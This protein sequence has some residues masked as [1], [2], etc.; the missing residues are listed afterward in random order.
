MK[1]QINWRE[2]F[3]IKG[4]QK[5]ITGAVDGLSD[6]FKAMIEST[7][8]D[9]QRLYMLN[10]EKQMDF[11]EEELQSL[12]DIYEVAKDSLSELEVQLMNT[13]LSNRRKDLKKYEVAYTKAQKKMSDSQK[14][15]FDDAEK[16]FSNITGKFD[17]IS[18]ALN[19]INLG[20]IANNIESSLGSATESLWAIRSS[21]NLTDSDMSEMK[22]YLSDQQKLLAQYG[23][24]VSK[25]EYY[26]SVETVIKEF[27][28]RDKEMAASLGAEMAK[29]RDSL[30]ISPSS[31]K[32][33]VEAVQ[34]YGYSDDF[35]ESMGDS[36]KSLESTYRT[37]ADSMLVGYERMQGQIERIA[38]G[39]EVVAQQ[40]SESLF[41]AIALTENQ[42]ISSD[43]MMS[44]FEEVLAG[45]YSSFGGS[46]VSGRKAAELIQSGRYDEAAAEILTGLGE[47]FARENNPIISAA[48][49]DAWDISQSDYDAIRSSIKE[50]A[51]AF[52]DTQGQVIST[53]SKATGE[54]DRNLKETKHV[55]LF[56]KASNWLANTGIGDFV[57]NAQESLG[58]NWGELAQLYGTVKMAKSLGGGAGGGGLLSSIKGWF[59]GGSAAAPAV[60]ESVGGGAGI[61]SKVGGLASQAAPWL[62]GI[63]GGAG[64][65]SGI[66]DLISSNEGTQKERDI[67]SKSGNIKLSGVALGAGI[68][69]LIPGVGTLIGAGV[70]GLAT[71]IFGD[72]AARAIS[73]WMDGTARMESTLNALNEASE[74]VRDTWEQKALTE[75]LLDR[76]SELEKG[77]KKAAKGTSEYNKKQKELNSVIG[78]LSSIYPEYVGLNSDNL[79]VVND[80]IESI[81]KLTEAEQKLSQVRAEEATK[82]AVEALPDYIETQK[83]AIESVNKSGDSVKALEN[84][85]SLLTGIDALIESGKAGFDDRGQVESLEE[86]S[87]SEKDALDAFNTNISD[88]A[89]EIGLAGTGERLY[90]GWES[91][92]LSSKKEKIL[93]D[94]IDAQKSKLEAD[95]KLEKTA[96]ELMVGL[97]SRINGSFE[98]IAARY[99]EMSSSEQSD[100][101]AAVVQ[102]EKAAKEFKG[103]AQYSLFPSVEKLE[104]ITQAD[105]N[106]DSKKI[107]TMEEVAARSEELSSLFRDLGFSNLADRITTDGSHAGGLD[108]VPFDGYR[109]E[110]HEG[111]KVLTKQEASEYSS[112]SDTSYRDIS[113]QLSKG[114]E[115]KSFK[116]SLTNIFSETW[117][118]AYENSLD[119]MEEVDAALI[120]RN[121]KLQEKETR[122]NSW[123]SSLFSKGSY[124]TGLDS[125]PYD[126]YQATLHS[127]ERI[128]TSDESAAYNALT[129]NNAGGTTAQGL[130]NS[131]IDI[132]AKYETGGRQNY[133]GL[134]NDD[135]GASS[136]GILQWRADRAQN[137]MQMIRDANPTEFNKTIN[138]YGASTLANM[139]NSAKGSQWG[140][141]KI[142]KNSGDDK[143][144]RELLGSGTG[145]QMQEQKANTDVTGYLNL[146]KSMGLS[147]SKALA[148]FADMVNQTGS[149]SP[150]MKATTNTAVSQGGSLDAI[151]KAALNNLSSTKTRRTGV[152]NDLKGMTLPGYADGN[153]RVSEDQIAAIHKDELI[154]PA[155]NNPYKDGL[156]LPMEG[157]SEIVKVLKE[158]FQAILRK[159]E[160]MK[161]N[162]SSESSAIMPLPSQSD[163]YTML[164]RAGGYSR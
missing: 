67:K 111:E 32:P 160:D 13:F 47:S 110:L 126:G 102:L 136:F 43:K 42:N 86:L 156:T 74:E 62:G 12:G 77:L 125:V 53:L 163:T 161:S 92:D 35:V 132:I 118:A 59:G 48:Y 121:T 124:A 154:V 20:S 80:S 144:A 56:E 34:R 123:L 153:D 5:E 151:Y 18:D 64:I 44:V 49:R 133:N 105:L 30:E 128:L 70:G 150:K 24:T 6:N 39:N 4:M 134:T 57:A 101:K 66:S 36:L 96:A 25:Q 148:F 41:A 9:E 27:G 131:V 140:S 88:Y 31:F 73:D 129:G 116:E 115:E 54:L 100:F 147:D 78:E 19:T 127:G 33:I 17:S 87:K 89:K 7:N 60:G 93:Q 1:D 83:K 97:E 55:G 138:Q 11:L 108:R 28:I 50:N 22:G 143:A 14:E 72:A 61:L 81:R 159:M 45:N 52:R 46:A 79:N 130:A 145:R 90:K 135:V 120:K 109:A 38:Q 21:L 26:E 63:A 71:L 84:Y 158:G 162:S 85:E 2:F 37:S 10:H 103:T 157:G 23:G 106:S 113:K 82:K 3:D 119:A 155:T 94:E 75:P 51:N 152:Y 29:W 146:G 149:G 95:Q 164:S 122:R 16:G 65:I 139:V 8:R 68:G 99:N 91:G 107:L 137:L 76:Y 112:T 69:S 142:P 104:Q 114:L 141:Y 15:F 117:I 58:M 40:A 98:D